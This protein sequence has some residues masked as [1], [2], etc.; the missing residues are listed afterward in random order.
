MSTAEGLFPGMKISVGALSPPLHEQLG[1]EARILEAE[2][3]DIDAV[4]RLRIRRVISETTADQA[5]RRVLKEVGRQ[6]AGRPGPTD[7]NERHQAN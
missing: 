4:N 7:E 2:Q 3:Q 5:V 1:I 6:L